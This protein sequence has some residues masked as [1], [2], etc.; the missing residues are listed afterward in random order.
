VFM[1]REE[2]LRQRKAARQD[3]RSTMDMSE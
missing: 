2:A 3:R 1:A